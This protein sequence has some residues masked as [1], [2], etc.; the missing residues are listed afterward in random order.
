M[1][2]PL[3]KYRVTLPGGRDTVMKLNEADAKRYDAEPIDEAGESAAAKTPEDPK[4]PAAPS[5]KARQARGKAAPGG[6]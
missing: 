1:G 5:N 4:Q 3:R 6:G 2:G